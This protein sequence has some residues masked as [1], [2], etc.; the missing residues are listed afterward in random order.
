MKS[1]EIGKGIWT[2]G[3]RRRFKGRKEMRDR[4]RHRKEGWEFGQTGKEEGLE[5][6]DRCERKEI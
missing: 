5:E 2:K 1:Q 6:H 4:R 3:Q